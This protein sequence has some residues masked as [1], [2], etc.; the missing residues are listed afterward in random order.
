MV[1]LVGLGCH[2]IRSKKFNI[3]LESFTDCGNIV[4]R[5]TKAIAIAALNTLPI[6]LMVGLRFLVPSIGVRV[7]DRQPTR[8]RLSRTRRVDNQRD[9]F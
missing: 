8:E 2:V 1:S 6:R 5:A 7:P 3:Q 4:Q 9:L